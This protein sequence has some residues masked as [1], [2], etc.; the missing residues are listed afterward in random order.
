MTRYCF[1]CDGAAWARTAAKSWALGGVDSF[2]FWTGIMIDGCSLFVILKALFFACNILDPSQIQFLF[3]VILSFWRNSTHTKH[4]HAFGAS[5][6]F[7]LGGSTSEPGKETSQL[8]RAH[9]AASGMR[10]AMMG[11]IVHPVI[12]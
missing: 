8:L 6:L 10:L 5:A 12:T 7:S 2:F 11:A 3:C 9:C 1:F 4:M